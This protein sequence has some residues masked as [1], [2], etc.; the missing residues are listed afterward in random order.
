MTSNPLQHR[1]NEWCCLH[2]HKAENDHIGVDRSQIHTAL[3]KGVDI[4]SSDRPSQLPLNVDTL[5]TSVSVT[6]WLT[7]SPSIFHIQYG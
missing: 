3:V 2:D 6:W 5:F 7:P 4:Q 1:Q